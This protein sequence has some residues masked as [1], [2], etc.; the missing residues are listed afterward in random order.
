MQNDTI[1]DSKK[2]WNTVKYDGTSGL[3]GIG[4]AFTQPLRWQKN[5]FIAAGAFLTGTGFLY[6]ADNEAQRYFSQQEEHA[7]QILQDF[8]WYFGCPQNFFM[9]SAGIY[10]FGLITNNENVRYTGVLIIS[11]AVASGLFQSITKHAIGRARPNEGNRN[12][13]EA[14]SNNSGFH[15][16]PSGH[17]ILSFTMAHAIAKQFDSFWVKTGIYAIGA[18][19]PISRLWKNAHWIS[20]IG[21][22]T[23]FSIVIVDGMDNFMKRNKRYKYKSPKQV[24]WQLKVGYGT[25][26]L[27]GSF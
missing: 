1:S 20:D 6:L 7:P 17:A 24:S 14:F 13:F 27:V 3:K 2:I 16:F 10:G 19:A 8:G 4:N 12:D 9:V 15:S 11:S 18:I 5:D 21:F 25:V 26:G 22:G 23:A